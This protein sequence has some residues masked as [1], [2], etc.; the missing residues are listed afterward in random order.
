[1]RRGPIHAEL[2]LNEDGAFLIEIAG[3]SIGGLCAQTL[4]FGSDESLETLILKEA[5]GLPIES[6]SREPNPRGVMMIPIPQAGLL[7][8]IAGISQAEAVPLVEKVEITAQLNNLLVS[9]PAGDSY[10]G[11]IFAK[12][13]RKNSPAEVEIALRQAHHHLQFQID[14]TLPVLSSNNL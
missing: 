12:G 7:R 4:H 11:F 9:L 6:L 14:P 8:D 5:V 13:S 1:M 10:L 3:R 2:R